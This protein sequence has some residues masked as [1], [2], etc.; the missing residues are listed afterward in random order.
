MP[1]VFFNITK[2]ITKFGRLLHLILVLDFI[3]SYEKLPVNR[4]QQNV[5]RGTLDWLLLD[6]LQT[7]MIFSGD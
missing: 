1:V 3:H 7:T 5:G 6:V 4:N 2:G